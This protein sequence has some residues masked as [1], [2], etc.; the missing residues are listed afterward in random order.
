MNSCFQIRTS[1]AVKGDL[2][3]GAVSDADVM[4]KNDVMN[5]KCNLRDLP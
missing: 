5:F 3:S 1:T 4:V 2:I